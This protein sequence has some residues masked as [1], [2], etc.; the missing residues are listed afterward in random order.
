VI[1]SLLE[2]GA[3]VNAL[4]GGRNALWM[5]LR[6][7]DEDDEAVQLLREHSETIVDEPDDSYENESDEYESDEDSDKN[8]L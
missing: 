6:Y 2:H 7:L 5:A 3:D 4:V 8:E 1:E